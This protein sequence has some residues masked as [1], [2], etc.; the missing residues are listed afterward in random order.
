MTDARYRAISRD[1]PDDGRLIA[2]VEDT[3]TSSQASDEEILDRLQAGFDERRL[4][5]VDDPE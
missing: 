4:R 2:V 3:G 5:A 1:L